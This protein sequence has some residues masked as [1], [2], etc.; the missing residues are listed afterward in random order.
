[1]ALNTAPPAPAA[2]TIS[3]ANAVVRITAPKLPEFDGTT[4]KEEVWGLRTRTMIEGSLGAYAD[5]SAVRL[6]ILAVI[7]G[8]ASI[9]AH[10]SMP[11]P[12]A[13]GTTDAAKQAAL[14]AS[15]AWVT[16]TYGDPTAAVTANQEYRAFRQGDLPFPA[17]RAELTSLRQRAGLSVGDADIVDALRAKMLPGLLA[18][19]SAQVETDL[20]T[21]V[22]VCTAHEPAV[23]RKMA[24][25]AKEGGKKRGAA[26]KGAKATAAP[27]V[28]VVNEPA[29]RKIRVRWPADTPEWARKPNANMSA[30]E[31]E[32]VVAE[33]LCFGCH[34]AGHV[35]ADCPNQDR[36]DADEEARE[37]AAPDEDGDAALPHKDPPAHLR[38]KAAKRPTPRNRAPEGE[39]LTAHRSA[40][41]EFTLGGKICKTRA[42][43]LDLGISEKIVLGYDWLKK[44]NP[45]ID[46]KNETLSWRK[47]FRAAGLR[48][49]DA[50]N[51]PGVKS[52][53]GVPPQ[54]AEFADVFDN[55]DTAPVPRVID[56]YEY[57]I[58]FIPGSK[59]PGPASPIPL[60]PKDKA[61][62]K[63]QIES[64]IK[65]GQIRPSSS[66][67][68]CASF[69]VNK[70]CL[71]CKLLRCT[72]GKKDYERRWVVDFRPINRITDQDAF[73]LPP[74]NDLLS[75]FA[76]K[77]H[78]VKLD[79]MWM[80]WTFAVKEDDRWKTAFVTSQGLYEWN[81]MPFG[82]KNAPAHSQ[83]TMNQIL[84][85]VQHFCR[86][87]IDDILIVGDTSEQ[88]WER[89]KQ[90]L[91]I[92]RQYG[93]RA[94]LKKCDFDVPSTTYL[95]F[96]IGTFGLKPDPAKVKGIVDFPDIRSIR[97]IQSFLGILN[98]YRRFVK[99]LTKITVPL[100]DL[101]G[102]GNPSRFERLPEKA[103]QAVA[104]CKA[105]WAQELCLAPWDPEK[106]VDLITDASDV[107]FGIVIEQ[108]GKPIT[109]SSGKFSAQGRGWTTTE[110][111]LYA[112]VKAHK[113]FG[114]MLM[115][116]ETRWFT[117]H[118][119]LLSL[120]T[121]LATAGKVQRWV[122]FLNGF[123]FTI[124]YRPGKDMV[125]DGF[126][127]NSQDPGKPRP[128]EPIFGPE[129][130][131][132]AIADNKSALS[133]FIK[134]FARVCVENEMLKKQVSLG[135]NGQAQPKL[136]HETPDEDLADLITLPCVDHTG[137]GCANCAHP[138]S[139]EVARQ[140]QP[141]GGI[142]D[143]EKQ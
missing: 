68:G 24:A 114:Y 122:E 23:R 140:E 121:T 83:R 134:D 61:E 74:I 19:E 66:K 89:T 64:L 28:V 105:V 90:V 51:A 40:S 42:L 18:L 59:V 10:R 84:A 81:V 57:S 123:P 34:V 92:L 7:T 62:E 38:R 130:F 116:P 41:L 1:M 58:T 17:F 77:G 99:D 73:P 63:K 88:V 2:A 138:F 113:S 29:A 25:K 36:Q 37:D 35:N 39:T 79:L 32:Q 15:L 75:T 13:M 27:A 56:G 9:L 135:A 45:D 106:P 118:K 131:A 109:F 126:T 46:W 21:L 5:A 141:Q 103:A 44:A 49:F 137:P 60:S 82:L 76:G 129:R 4:S 125:A 8:R 110:R 98:Y 48:A 47:K 70:A 31:W 87:Y 16:A 115:H 54:L 86:A 20:V 128:T 120:K 12:A 108:N 33:G 95:G 143:P 14:D 119:A 100:S 85:P 132:A 91:K 104:I 3:T 50:K 139:D 69:F 127:R 107:A 67:T 112:C 80:F 93:F 136:S 43:I 26:A 71:S 96:V 53:P 117:D 72:C 124:H 133:D 6:A 101:T 30:T 111:E 22:R 11:V 55:T 78:Y 102:K 97:D 142:A 94:K 52:I 65:N